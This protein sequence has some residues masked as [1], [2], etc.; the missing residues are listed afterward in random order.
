M[1]NKSAREMVDNWLMKYSYL[2]FIKKIY[3]IF[4]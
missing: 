3:A 4:A 2:V 1:L